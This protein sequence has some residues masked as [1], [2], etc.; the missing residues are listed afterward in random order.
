MSDPSD[1]RCERNWENVCSGRA[2]GCH[3]DSHGHVLADVHRRS[4]QISAFN[5]QLIQDRRLSVPG[6]GCTLLSSFNVMHLILV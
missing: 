2:A 1:R 3:S 5:V 4:L 6:T